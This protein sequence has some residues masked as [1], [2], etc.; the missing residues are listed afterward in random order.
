MAATEP[1]A[2]RTQDTL[3]A[4]LGKTTRLEM[5][6]SGGQC[7]ADLAGLEAAAELGLD[8]SGWMP[9]GFRT[10]NGPKPHLAEMYGLYEM[11]TDSY[12]ER[13]MANV[14][15]GDATVAFLLVD[16][17]DMGA[18]TRKTIGYCLHGTWCS[19]E[20][21]DEWKHVVSK[22]RPVL[23]INASRWK[24]EDSHCDITHWDE[25][26]TALRTF[27]ERHAVHILNVAGHCEFAGYAVRILNMAEGHCEFVHGTWREAVRKFLVDTLQEYKKPEFARTTVSEAK[28]IVTRAVK[29]YYAE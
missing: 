11:K 18:G 15:L 26:A 22:H 16:K 21:E 1:A 13:T 23:V 8:T 9:K 7:G 6:V 10:E 4:W 29:A 12:R 25:D 19:P 2:P 14:D 24:V 28:K 3:C 17:P 20:D 27:L 5:I